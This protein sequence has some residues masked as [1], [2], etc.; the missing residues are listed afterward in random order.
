MNIDQGLTFDMHVQ[1]KTQIN[2]QKKSVLIC[3]YL[4]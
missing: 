4:W 2:H 3:V 1:K